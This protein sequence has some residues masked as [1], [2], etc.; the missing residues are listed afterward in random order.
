MSISA[1]PC[2]CRLKTS[3]SVSNPDTLYIETLRKYFGY[4]SFRSIQ[5]DIIRS[6][7]SGCDT[8]GLMPTGGG[9]SITF[10]VPALT[11]DGVCLVITPLIALMK[12]QVM[13]LK[14]RGIKAEAIHS[15]LS[16]DDILRILDNASFGAVKFL[17]V[18]PERLSSP[19]FL[20]KLRYIDICFITVD[21]AHCISQWGYDF[22]PSYLHINS[23]REVLP[24]VPVLALTAT[25]TPAVVDDIRD[26]LEFGKYTD[27]KTGLYQMSFRR[28][29]LSYVVRHTDDK[30]AETVHILQSVPGSAIVYTRNRKGTKDISDLLNERGISAT[31]YHAGLDFAI[32]DTRQQEWQQGKFRVMV[33]TNAFGMGIDKPD[34]RLVIHYDCPD[35]LE[36]YFQEA[37]RAGRDDKRSYAILLSYDNDRKTLMRQ[38]A[39][40]FPKKEYIRQVYDHLAYYFQLPEYMGEGAHFEFDRDRFCVKFH[41]YPTTLEAALSILQNAGYIT[42]DPSPDSLPRVM[43]QV[44]RHDLYELTG[45]SPAEDTVI[46]ALLRYYGSLFSELTF[47]VPSLM[48]RACHIDEHRLHQILKSLAQRHIIRYVPRRDV[49]VITYLTQRIPSSQISISR[50]VY[51]NLQ[52]RMAERISKVLEYLTNR[53]T[54]RS[55]LLLDYFGEY[56]STPCQHCDVCIDG[57][58]LSPSSAASSYPSVARLMEIIGDH[59]P[60]SIAEIAASL[61]VRDPHLIRFLQQVREQVGFE[62]TCSHVTLKE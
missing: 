35:S 21:E 14:A 30:F 7:G 41:H 28:D 4:D 5:L 15:S 60:H 51:E 17:Y 32:K 62:L 3:I 6:I 19:L 10:Q 1:A 13:H 24:D 8:L 46:D 25:A 54:C 50:D 34:V 42:Y 12:D 40:A 18:S 38:A 36:A 33:A 44:S 26:K 52:Q 59:K 56:G 47:I 22:R 20:A 57:K 29:N 48:A 2:S 49:P 45:I 53:D 9:K 43:F 58:G 39:D 31:F 16:H 11:M 61:D 27:G 37:G 55:M 23:V